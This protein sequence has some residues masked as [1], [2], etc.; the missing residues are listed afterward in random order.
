MSAYEYDYDKQNL[1]KGLLPSDIDGFIEKPISLNKLCTIVVDMLDHR[2]H[3]P[4]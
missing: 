1:G 4:T 2:L 3:V